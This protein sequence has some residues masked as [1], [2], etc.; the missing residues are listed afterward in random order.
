MKIQQLKEEHCKSSVN[1]QQNK[2]KP[3]NKQRKAKKPLH[4][5]NHLRVLVVTS[6][7]G[8]HSHFHNAANIS[9]QMS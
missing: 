7:H 9:L 2:T 1:N 8:L 5:Q 6:K 3:T 4:P